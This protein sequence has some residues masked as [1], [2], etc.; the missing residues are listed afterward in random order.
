MQPRTTEPEDVQFVPGVTSWDSPQRPAATGVHFVPLARPPQPPQDLGTP[1]TFW[2]RPSEGY[3]DLLPPDLMPGQVRLNDGTKTQGST[4]A[5]VR[6]GE[7]VELAQPA[8]LERL[9][10]PLDV[11]VVGHGTPEANQGGSY[12]VFTLDEDGLIQ[13]ASEFT[14]PYGYAVEHL[15]Q[16]SVTMVTA[17]RSWWQINRTDLRDGTVTTTTTP[18]AV[19]AEQRLHV[20][21]PDQ[22]AL[23]PLRRKQMVDGAPLRTTLW[24]HRIQPLPPE[25]TQYLPGSMEGFFLVEALGWPEEMGWPESYAKVGTLEFPGITYASPPPPWP[26]FE[27]HSPDDQVSWV[28]DPETGQRTLTAY[29]HSLSG[30]TWAALRG[31]AIWDPKTQAWV[32][33][34]VT[35]VHEAGGIITAIHS[36]GTSEQC[37]QADFEAEVLRCPVGAF[38]GFAPESMGWPAW[39]PQWAWAHATQA[40]RAIVAWDAWRD[41]T[42]RHWAGRPRRR[43]ETDRAPPETRPPLGL[44]LASTAPRIVDA[45]P[46]AVGQPPFQLPSLVEVWDEEGQAWQPSFTALKAL[47]KR[48]LYRP[49]EWPEELDDRSSVAGRTRLRVTFTGPVMPSPDLAVVALM[50]RAKVSHGQRPEVHVN[51]ELADVLALGVNAGRRGWQPFLVVTTLSYPRL[52]PVEVTS[53]QPLS[54]LL[55]TRVTA[56]TIIET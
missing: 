20:V 33:A 25:D 49:A 10:L 40:A 36:D 24:G 34:A 1:A 53:D 12:Y 55:L 45:E 18:R 15:G 52:G 30:G 5:R 9:D 41:S 28:G 21:T 6:S 17:R 8:H 37:S 44:A 31:V 50:L 23:Q 42:L 38:Q 16:V 7:F 43:P 54:R 11:L 4:G 39:P 29:G 35:V 51:G 46:L 47:R 27:W 32:N 13:I 2:H 22:G 56:S 19:T 14:R 26:G 3:G 48:M